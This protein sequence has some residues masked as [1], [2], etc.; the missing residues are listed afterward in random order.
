MS[1]E[2]I[3][4]IVRGQVSYHGQWMPIEK[5]VELIARNRKKIEEGY[6]RYQGEWMT[7]EEK[8]SRISPAQKTQQPQQVTINQT[9]NQQTY[10][11]RTVDKR[12]V[13]EHKHVHLDAE[14]LAAYAKNRQAI[15]APSDISIEGDVRPAIGSKKRDKRKALDDKSSVQFLDDKSRTQYLEDKRKVENVREAEPA[16]TVEEVQ[17]AEDV[18]DLEDIRKKSTNSK[19]EGSENISD[20]DVEEF[21]G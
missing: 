14:T 3:G 7:I 21:L 9:F 20:A 19:T 10:D 15:G 17:D 13:H 5:K 18:V 8:L 12:T 6:V 11:Q 1:K 4:K 16:G 2:D